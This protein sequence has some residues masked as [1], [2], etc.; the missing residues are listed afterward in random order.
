MTVAPREDS[1]LPN[2]GCAGWEKQL[3]DFRPTL[4]L[5]SMCYDIEEYE[6]L[7]EEL[8]QLRKIGR[9]KPIEAAA[10]ITV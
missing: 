1:I 7:M 5:S 8:R 9:E 10:E 2:N 3:K 6:E 4:P